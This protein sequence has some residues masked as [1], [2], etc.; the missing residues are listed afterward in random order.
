MNIGFYEMNR[1]G[2]VFEVDET[3]AMA[4]SKDEDGR[5]IGFH[6]ASDGTI[7]S[8]IFLPVCLLFEDG[9]PQCFETAIITG[10]KSTVAKRYS[11]FNQAI[12]GHDSF[13][14]NLP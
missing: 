9:R 7:V 8:T 10:T 1:E 4:L 11:T 2:I 3:T 13:V 14:G 12:E 6:K 5:T